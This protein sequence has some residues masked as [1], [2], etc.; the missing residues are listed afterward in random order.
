M[1]LTN[2]EYLDVPYIPNEFIVI[3]TT[4]VEVHPTPFQVVAQGS[5]AVNPAVVHDHIVI[6]AIVCIFE[7]A[8][9]PHNA[10][11]VGAFKTILKPH[12]N[13]INT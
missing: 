6:P 3:E 10:T 7:E 1:Q 13:K 4:Y 9:R 11:S 12:T 5:V 2:F 8:I